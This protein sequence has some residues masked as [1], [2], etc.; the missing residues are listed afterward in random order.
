[1]LLSDGRAETLND[2]AHK[3]ETMPYVNIKSSMKRYT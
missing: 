1:M 2:F 3:E